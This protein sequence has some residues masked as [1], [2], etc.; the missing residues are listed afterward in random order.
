[1]VGSARGRNHVFS[2]DGLEGS[3]TASWCVLAGLLTLGITDGVPGLKVLPVDHGRLLHCGSPQSG[4]SLVQRPGTAPGDSWSLRYCSS[5]SLM[6]NRFWRTQSIRPWDWSVVSS[7]WSSSCWWPV[8][9]NPLAKGLRADVMLLVAVH[10]VWL[11][12]AQWFGEPRLTPRLVDIWLVLC[13]NGLIAWRAGENWTR[14]VAIFTGA[15]AYLL[16]LSLD[17]KQSRRT[18]NGPLAGV[19]VRAAPAACR[20]GVQYLEGST[21]GSAGSSARVKLVRSLTPGK[22]FAFLA[23]GRRTTPFPSMTGCEVPLRKLADDEE[24]HWERRR[25]LGGNRV[26]ARQ[27]WKCDSCLGCVRRC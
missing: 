15:V 13:G 11:L 21:S 19:R 16:H 26:A 7:N 4:G 8:G 24:K 3:R 18:S 20:G 2:V 14:Q 22:R 17:S 27:V 10:G 12:G 5:R 9:L 25:F 23:P 1:M 6:E